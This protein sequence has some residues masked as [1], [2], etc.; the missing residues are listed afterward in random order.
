MRSDFRRAIHVDF[1]TMSGIYDINDFD[2]KKFAETMADAHVTYVN[3]F[4]ECNLGFCYYP[5]KIGNVYPG[6]KKDMLGELV[7]ELHKYDIGVTAYI[8]CGLNNDVLQPHPDWWRINK[9]G[10]LFDATVIDGKKVYPRYTGCFNTGYGDYLKALVK[11]IIDNY[12]V[13]GIFLDCVPMGNCFCEKCKKDM[14]EQGVDMNDEPSAYKFSE[15][16]RVK[17]ASEIKQIVGKE[18]HLFFNSWYTWDL[19]LCDHFELEC[20]PNGSWT[21]EYFAPHAAFARGL[22][23]ETLYMTGRFQI[24][25][26]DFG[27]ICSKASL[28]HDMFDAI[29]NGFG[30]SVGDHAHPSKTL[31]PKLYKTIKEIYEDLTI[32]QQYTT[33]GKYM[34]DIGIYS[35]L[36]CIRKYDMWKHKYLSHLLGDLKYTYNVITKVDAIKDYPLII[37]PEDVQLTKEEAKVFDEYVKNGGKIISCGEAGLN[38]NK[39]DFAIQE[40]KDLVEYCGGDERYYSF[41]EFDGVDSEYNDVQWNTYQPAI[42]MRAKTGQVIAQDVKGYFD[43]KYDGK[44]VNLYFP[45][46]KKTGYHA[47]VVGDNVAHVSFD[48]FKAYGKFFSASHRDLM[49]ILLEKLMPN[50]LIK[51]SELPVSS[52]ATVIESDKYLTLNI[53]TTFPEIRGAF[54]DDCKGVITEH[55]YL[56]AGRKVSVKGTGFKSVF[57]AKTGETI[58][59]VE[60]DGYTEITLPEICGFIEVVLEK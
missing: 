59:C 14:Q 40:F 8:N 41:F 46:E 2:A 50:N 58:A 39:T 21:Y 33:G 35:S 34:A 36:R 31:I 57:S 4:A 9:D 44:R 12:D 38:E 48:L 53:K 55:V 30:Y 26:G 5:T 11:E 10:E 49:R 20:L 22:D 24:E 7:T 6:L 19:D 28:E 13:D 56:P 37:I 3:V 47:A 43:K 60:N 1:H 51:A 42:M 25:W 17:F 18:H 23:K 54:V 45:P 15:D 32:Y 27:G 52:R 29:M 16:V